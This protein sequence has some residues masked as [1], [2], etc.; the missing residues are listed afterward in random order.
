MTAKTVNE[1]QLSKDG[2]YHSP[3]SAYS[4]P[5]INKMQRHLKKQKGEEWE[6]VGDKLV[7]KQEAPT[8]VKAPAVKEKQP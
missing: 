7:L 6:K 4:T 8:A 5:L 3:Y 2:R 1:I